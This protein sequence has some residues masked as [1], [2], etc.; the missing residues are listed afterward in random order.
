MGELHN[1]QVLLL[2]SNYV[3]HNMTL[4][5]LISNVARVILF[6][7]VVIMVICDNIVLRVQICKKI[8]T[9]ILEI[10]QNVKINY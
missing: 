2:T 5:F 7:E 10:W 8:A 3:Y 1:L 4:R 6:V 9:Y